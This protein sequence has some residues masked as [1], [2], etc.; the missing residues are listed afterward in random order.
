MQQSRALVI[1]YEAG[2]TDQV[3]ALSR[4]Q[5][6]LLKHIPFDPRHLSP[7]DRHTLTTALTESLAQTQAIASRAQQWRDDVAALIET[8]GTSH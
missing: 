6:A 8:L 2:N 4:Q 1:A 3:L 5:Q 7:E